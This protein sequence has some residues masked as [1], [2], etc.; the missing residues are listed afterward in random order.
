MMHSLPD[1]EP[2]I[3][4]RPEP[5]SPWSG[6]DLIVFG[7]FFGATTVFVPAAIVRLWRISDPNLRLTQLTALDQVLLQGMIDLALVGFIAFLVRVVHREGFLE[8]IH[9]FPNYD[10]TTGSLIA[11][12]A[13]LAIIV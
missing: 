7:I 4:R 10:F 13:V 9:W 1:P 5:R 6:I 11:M 2:E 3:E 8:T 12:G